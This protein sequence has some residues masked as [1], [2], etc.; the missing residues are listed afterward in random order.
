MGEITFVSTTWRYDQKMV[1]CDSRRGPSTKSP[2]VPAPWSQIS[3]LQN[4]EKRM[5]FLKKYKPARLWYFVLGAQAKIVAYQWSSSFV[6]RDSVVWFFSF[7][8]VHFRQ[9][10]HLLW[11]ESNTDQRPAGFLEVSSVLLQ[12]VLGAVD[13]WQLRYQPVK[14]E[15]EVLV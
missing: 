3:R 2:T 11:K 12:G 5:S 13:D 1:V 4:G 8:F 7:L 9:I 15:S 14:I 6:S 10:N